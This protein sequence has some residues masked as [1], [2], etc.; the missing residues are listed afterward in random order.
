MIFLTGSRASIL[1]VI[2]GL[3]V[4]TF[5][6]LPKMLKKWALIAAAAGC[7]AFVTL[8]AGKITGAFYTYF[9]APQTIHDFSE[10]LPSNVGRANLLKNAGH[11]VLDTYG[12]GVGAGNVPYYLEHHALFYTDQVVEVHNWLVEIM[13][14]F[15]VVMMLGYLTMYI[16][17]IT[18]LYRYYKRSLGR[19]PK[20]L[21]EGLTAALVAFLVS[22]ISPSSVSNLYFHWVFLALVIAAIN[23]FRISGTDETE[24]YR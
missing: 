21:I 22:S 15:G 16:Y 24:Q 10:P 1:G 13:T 8:F 23:T 9:L 4:Y 19:R 11:Y 5:I 20:L 17:L 14:N 2:A 3:A 7:I 12:F 6:L 18:V